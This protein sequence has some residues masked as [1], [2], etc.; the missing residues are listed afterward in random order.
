MLSAGIVVTDPELRNRIVH[1]LQS[2]LRAREAKPRRLTLAGRGRPA[3]AWTPA[4]Q[5]WTS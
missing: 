3:Q 4:P 5:L 2:C 1:G